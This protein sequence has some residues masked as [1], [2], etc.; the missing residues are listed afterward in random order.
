MKRRP[1]NNSYND[2]YNDYDRDDEYLPPEPKRGKPVNNN[3]PSWFNATVIAVLAG[4]FVLGIG[5]G[6]AFSA[7]TPT[8]PT[9]VVTNLQI[10]QQAPNPEVCIQNGASAM[11]VSTRLYVTLNPFKVFVAQ[12]GMEPACIIR[13][14]NWSV[15]EQR[16]LLTAEQSRDCRQKMNTFGYIGNL[17]NKD[18]VTIDCVYQSDNAKNLFLG[19]ASTPTLGNDDQF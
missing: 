15:L 16:K 3:N 7:A 4:I 14:A 6:I 13:R 1:R 12:A 9:S 2:R 11:A 10:D 8:N 19:G 18:K 17:D 5:V